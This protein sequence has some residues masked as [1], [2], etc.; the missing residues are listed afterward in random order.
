MLRWLPPLVTAVQRSQSSFFDRLAGLTLELGVDHLDEQETP[1][2]I[3]SLPE[4]PQ[5]AGQDSGLKDIARALTTPPYSGLFLNRET[6]SALARKHEIPRGF[7]DREQMLTNLL[8]TAGQYD[9]AG[10]IFN[11][12]AGICL[13]WSGS[14][15]KHCD[16]LPILQPWIRPWQERVLQTAETLQGLTALIEETPPQNV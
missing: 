8:R 6:I 1:A 2:Y 13:E 16:Q 14:Y 4:S 11:D 7:G 10:A 12:L 9:A 15:Q 3:D 5:L